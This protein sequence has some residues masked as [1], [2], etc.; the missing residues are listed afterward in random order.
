MRTWVF[1]FVL[2]SSGSAFAGYGFIEAGTWGR[3]EVQRVYPI[4]DQALVFYDYDCE[5]WD[6]SDPANP[7][8]ISDLVKSS[9]GHDILRTQQGVYIAGTNGSLDFIDLQDPKGPFV[10]CNRVENDVVIALAS[11]GERLFF[12]KGD[13]L[14]VLNLD[15]FCN[16][17]PISHPI[18]SFDLE[19]A[20]GEAY[21][22]AAG[23]SQIQVIS[24]EAGLPMITTLPF[25]GALA[26]EGERL[27]VVSDQLRILDIGLPEQP[28]VIAQMPLPARGTGIRP[29]G[30]YLW[31]EMSGE[32][33]FLLS[34][35]GDQPQILDQI[36]IAGDLRGAVQG[37]HLYLAGRY[38]GLHVL[39]RRNQQIFPRHHLDDSG[40]AHYAQTNGDVLYLAHGEAGLRIFDVRTPTPLPI[41]RWTHPNFQAV[42]YFTRQDSRLIIPEQGGVWSVD[43]SQPEQPVTLDN[44]RLGEE[45]PTVIAH[46]GY[47]YAILEDR[48]TTIQMSKDGLL[49][50]VANTDLTPSRGPFDSPHIEDG[51]LWFKNRLEVIAVDLTT[52]SSPSL[53]NQ[54]LEPASLMEVGNG[55]VYLDKSSAVESFQIQPGGMLEYSE[56]GPARFNDV[57][58][59]VDQAL[60]FKN[61]SLGLFNVS[62]PMG[63]LLE[64][65]IRIDD[66]NARLIPS[67]ED[68]LLLVKGREGTVMPSR[69]RN[70]AW[71]L[72]AWGEQM[73]ILDY[74]DLMYGGGSYSCFRQ[75]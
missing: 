39:Q 28:T 71:L 53:L 2:A 50:I 75:P 16:N 65:V 58:A 8:Y 1:L 32:G 57:L 62:D 74:V 66:S 31:L 73:N 27:Y 14:E 9:L 38:S 4:G 36:Q 61:F 11:D 17:Q 23:A 64:G 37:D 56:S 52:P 5:L 22:Y 7:T 42:S 20:P 44:L 12:S 24:T 25:S 43:V 34:V 67:G 3:P 45:Q 47:I 30:D 70:R 26:V 6:I 68:Y 15:D 49:S 40:Y 48:V 19:M 55:Y 41:G 60:I 33:V 10:A 69:L 35:I 54:I 63:W 51:V 13:S 72:E 29:N 18:T 59:L 46:Q 21:L